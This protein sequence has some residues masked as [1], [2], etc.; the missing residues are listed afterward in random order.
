[1]P[2]IL[3]PPSEMVQLPTRLQTLGQSRRIVAVVAALSQTMLVLLV[4]VG[5][6]LCLDALVSLPAMIRVLLL[7]GIGTLAG[8]AFFAWLRPAWQLSTQPASIARLIETLDPRWNDRLASAVAF[9]TLDE[10]RNR[11][12]DSVIRTVTSQAEQWNDSVIVPKMRMWLLF[13][14]ALFVGGLACLTIVTQPTLTLIGVVRLLDPYGQHPWPTA[15]SVVIV[16]P[17]MV[18]GE[19]FKM[20]RGTP[21][22][23]HFVVDGEKPETATLEIRSVEGATFLNEIALPVE[24]DDDGNLIENIETIEAST[25]IESTQTVRDFAFRVVANDGVSDWHDVRVFSAPTLIPWEGRPSPQISLS[26][27]A[28]TQLA[29]VQLPDASGVVDGVVG[30]RIQLHALADRPIVEARLE[31]LTDHSSLQIALPLMTVIADNPLSIIGATLLAE[32]VTSDIPVSVTSDNQ[33]SVDFVPTL[34]GLYELQFID[35]QGLMGH[36]ILDFRLFIDPTPVATIARP[37]PVEDTLSYLPTAMLTVELAAEDDRFGIRTLELEYRHGNTNS[38]QRL[39]GIDHLASAEAEQLLA[40]AA[41]MGN[42][43]PG[44]QKLQWVVPIAAL[45]T[46]TGEAPQDG[47][48]ILLRARSDDWDNR[49]ANKKPG[50]SPWVTIEVLSDESLT[51]WLEQQLAQLRSSFLRVQEKHRRIQS[52]TKALEE[53]INDPARPFDLAQLSQIERDQCELANT[54]RDA[55]QGLAKQLTRLQETIRKNNLPA[56]PV[57]NK[58]ETINGEM[59]QIVGQQL[60]AQEPLLVTLRMKAEQNPLDPQLDALLNRVDESQKSIEGSLQRITRQL[61][62]WGGPGEIRGQARNLRNQLQEL[63]AHANS[64]TTKATQQRTANQLNDLAKQADELLGTTSRLAAEQTAKADALDREAEALSQELAEAQKQAAANPDD[65]QQLLNVAKL[66]NDLRETEQAA[67]TARAAAEAMSQATRSSEGQGLPNQLRDAAEDL[68]AGRIGES[69]QGRDAALEQLDKFTAPLG[70]QSNTTP[71]QRT[72]QRNAAKDAIQELAEAQDELRKKIATAQANPDPTVQAEELKKLAP[73]QETLKKRADE[74][75]RTMELNRDR[76][77]AQALRRTSQSMSEAQTDLAE[78]QNPG[79]AVEKSL[80]EMN[81]AVDQL[82]KKQ[83]EDKDELL[84]EKRE[85]LTKPLQRLRDRQ[86]AT[87]NEA[88]RLQEQIIKAKQWDR[89]VLVSLSDLQERQVKIAEEL[90]L[91]TPE[92]ADW[93][94]FEAIGNHAATAMDLAVTRI[95]DRTFDTDPSAAFDAEL[96][97]N[98]HE[99]MTEPM[100]QA[101]KRLEMILQSIVEEP[102]KPEPKPDAPPPEQPPEGEP[103]P[104]PKEAP[105]IPPHA[106]LK[107]LRALQQ[108]I[109]T[110][111]AEFNAKHPNPDHWTDA[112]KA[113]IDELEVAQRTLGKLFDELVPR[114]LPKQEETL[115]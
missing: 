102:K 27:P 56:S 14:S 78:G 41:A 54:L 4:A 30:T 104:Q 50:F 114:L 3:R 47:D 103:P 59:E 86:E 105:M 90:R 49:T 94:V 55:E 31:P 45:S 89:G 110:A 97:A 58:V 13:W 83:D 20:V 6:A 91:L 35:E 81:D 62:A 46:P 42:R 48:R 7:A 76:T 44:T 57:T 21:L 34:A 109:V 115:P 111:T 85:A 8:I 32:S 1:M 29:P 100:A 108:E 61:E 107:A 113:K 80:E 5:F 36:Q 93:P 77:A 19:P 52:E 68:K 106:E 12:H 75:A 16:E 79:D 10:P 53:S 92:L 51:A 73:E 60:P 38:V 95:E 65:A 74:L 18:V 39:N 69:A 9:E 2:W 15:T 22:T 40:G 99:R 43:Q 88:N 17:V 33:L 82:D 112:D 64:D 101:L 98:A 87:L 96:E 70:E 24:H 25:T 67:A 66:E 37:S 26:F 72:T 23:I 63:D 71:Q 11:F 28:Y 84:R